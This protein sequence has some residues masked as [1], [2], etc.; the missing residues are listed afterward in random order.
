MILKV[1]CSKKVLFFRSWKCFLFFQYET[2]FCAGGNS[3]GDSLVDNKS[4]TSLQFACMLKFT[5]NFVLYTSYLRLIKDLIVYVYLPMRNA[6]FRL[7]RICNIKMPMDRSKRQ[8]LERVFVKNL[9]LELVKSKLKNSFLI[10]F[11]HL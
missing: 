4:L 5:Y 10:I 2:N 9:S 3:R 6:I 1:C 7:W 11:M 8:K